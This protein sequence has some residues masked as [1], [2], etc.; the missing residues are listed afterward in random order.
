M[1]LMDMVK[2]SAKTKKPKKYTG[3]M[4]TKTLRNGDVNADVSKMKQ[5]L[6]WAIDTNFKGSKKFGPVT[7]KA[8]KKFQKKYAKYGL[9]ADGVFGPRTLAIAKTIAKG[10]MP[11]PLQAWYYA[12]NDQ[13][14]WSK[15]Q[16]YEFDD[17]PTVAN[18]KKRGTCITFPAVS[19]Q[20]IGLLPKGKY[21]YLNPNTMRI[22]GNA[23]S[24]VKNH[25]EVFQLSYP[26]KTI[27]ALGDGIKK[28]DIVG[29][30]NPAYHTMVY[31]GKNSK[32]EPIFNTMGH[33]RA[34][35]TTYSYYANRKINMLVHIKKV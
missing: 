1:K 23:A 19:L 27:K 2:A 8:V 15:G 12:M 3:E 20:R 11:D 29:F 30:G 13:F 21:F 33:K 28:G 10:K 4:P 31:M 35:R 16:K 14:A 26:N 5:F 9:K 32:G 25:T 24:Y 6:N 22:S 17:E 34:L 7:E 18:S